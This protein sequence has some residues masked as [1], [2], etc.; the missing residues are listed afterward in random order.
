MINS[1]REY[2]CSHLNMIHPEYISYGRDGHPA[3]VP[4]LSARA[5]I[6]SNLILKSLKIKTLSNSYEMSGYVYLCL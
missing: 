5:A 1:F 4:F 2:E 6:L 3:R